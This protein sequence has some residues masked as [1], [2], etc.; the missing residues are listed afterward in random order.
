VNDQ[1]KAYAYGLGAVLCWSTVATAFKLSLDHV[2]PAQL[3][4]L[5]AAV[6]WLLLALVLGFTGNLSAIFRGDVGSYLHSMVLGALNPFLY[7]LVLLEAY[8]R[9]PAQE[10]Q[11]LNYTWALTMALLAVPLLRHPLK[12]LEAF[13]ALVCYCGVLVIATHGQLLSLEFV[14]PVGVALALGSTV[15][16]AF[17]WLLN[18]SEQRDPVL[19]LFLNFSFALPLLLAYC[20]WRGEL[21]AIPWQ[22]VAG[23]LYVGFF[24]MGLSFILW[25][26]AM[27]LTRSTLRISS[28]IFIAPP[29]SLVLIHF[30]LGE[31]IM[32]STLV[33][34]ALILAGLAMQNLKRGAR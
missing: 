31:A 34:L 26:K 13:A 33:G 19:A 14:N 7:Y 5:A 20:A 32:R 11:A 2:S 25:L 18:T 29:L 6:S 12:A 9:L 15:L 28:L 10:A 16:W 22:G 23:A 3:V 1:Q 24:E 17:Y 8:A 27:R 21:H 30:V 4:L